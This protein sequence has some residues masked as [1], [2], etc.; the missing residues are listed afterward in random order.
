MHL[1]RDSWIKL[2]QSS[3]NLTQPYLS[4]SFTCLRKLMKSKHEAIYYRNALCFIVTFKS[5][6]VL[7]IEM[8]GS[9]KI[10][11][12]PFDWFCDIIICSS[13]TSTVILGKLSKIGI[14][15]V[16][17]VKKSRESSVKIFHLF[18]CQNVRE[19]SYH[20]SALH[21]AGHAIAH[22]CYGLWYQ[23]WSNIGNYWKY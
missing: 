11:C 21:T 2:I 6:E 20:F 8:T 17:W 13:D 5:R 9:Q 18:L 22:D 12:H 16:I 3:R 23:G 4:T 15:C 10:K 1:S 7:I 14:L 19:I